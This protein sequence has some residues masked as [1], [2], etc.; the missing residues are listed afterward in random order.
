MSIDHYPLPPVYMRNNK[1]CFLDPIRNSLIVITPEE[2][3]RQRMV[4]YLQDVL[5]APKEMIK[6]EEP[7]TYFQKGAKGR[8]DII[9]YR[10]EED[11]LY[12]VILVECK[13]P[14]IELTDKVFEQA[15]KYDQLI[16]ADVLVL[17]NGKRA[18]WYAW[19]EEDEQYYL[20][21]EIPTYL[22]LLE[23]RPLHYDRSE[24]Y[25]WKRPS[26]G[27]LSANVTYINF[28]GMGW[29]GEGTDAVLQGFIMNLSGCLQDSVELI[30]PG[31]YEGVH[32]IRDGGIRNT[33][34]G[35]AAGGSWTGEYRYVVIEDEDKNNQIISF[36]ILGEM[37][38]TNDPVFGNRKGHSVLVVAIDDFDK[39]HNSLQLNLDRYTKKEDDTTF[40]IWH[41]GKLTNGKKGR[42][43]N[44]DVI[45]YIKEYAPGLLDENDQVFLGRFSHSKNFRIS[46]TEMK[47]FLGRILKYS[48]IRDEYRRKNS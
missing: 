19:H 9:V 33:R 31:Y 36:A 24:P 25:V 37:K 26:F 44:S 39:S 5:G 29:I 34:F 21:T 48:L 17:T 43:R 12:S 38:S 13:S 8:A 27:S 14:D 22:S 30:N 10:K 40:T 4:S 23:N 46:D 2:I 1:E 6:L 20:L 15:V 42:V 45:A 32:V 35:N 47:E 7:M 11:E 28:V 3:V 16:T 18:E 41:D